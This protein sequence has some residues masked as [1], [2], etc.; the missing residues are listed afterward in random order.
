MASNSN[1]VSFMNLSTDHLLSSCFVSL[2]LSFIYVVPSLLGPSLFSTLKSLREIPRS[3]S[4]DPD[5]LHIT[6][7]E[8]CLSV[9]VIAYRFKDRS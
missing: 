8:Q 9:L 7:S 5:F 2:N 1:V 3:T 6:D 4:P